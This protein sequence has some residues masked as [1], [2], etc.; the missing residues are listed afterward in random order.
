MVILQVNYRF[1]N[2]TPAQWEARYTDA[3]GEKF[4]SVDGLVWK[5][6]LDGVEPNC[7]GGV[8]LFESLPQ[9]E[10]Y[11]AGPIVAGMRANPNVT[12]LK[13]TLSNVREQI[14]AIT[15][16]P[17]PGLVPVTRLAAE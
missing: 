8:Y 15:Y 14:S 1:Q 2:V 10:A 4:L 3:T 13:T 7:V 9:A 16:A 11:L 5:V 6:W 12:D 17:V